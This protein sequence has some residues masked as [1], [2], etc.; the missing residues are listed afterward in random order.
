RDAVR[1][2]GRYASGQSYD[3]LVLGLACVGIAVTAGTYASLGLGVPARVGL[4][5][6]KAAR[7]AG[8]IADPMASW[9]G[10]SLR[11][12]VDWAAMKRASGSLAEPVAAVR[13]VREAVKV[14]NAR[15]LTRLVGDVGRVQARAG[16]GAAL[17][18]LKMAR[19][20]AELARIARLAENKGGKTR[21][22]LKTL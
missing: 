20:P 18:G 14:E 7:K 13:A 1:E 4:S 12:T 19:D 9:I 22:I 6:M 8:R 5:A 10:R 2:G 3:Q 11:D 16:T 15:G 17:D 21:A